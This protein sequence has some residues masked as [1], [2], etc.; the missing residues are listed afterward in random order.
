MESQGCVDTFGS[1]LCLPCRPGYQGDGF[2]CLPTGTISVAPSSIFQTASVGLSAALTVISS[3]NASSTVELAPSGLSS[4]RFS[5]YNP[6]GTL[7]SS[8]TLNLAANSNFTFFVV[9]P[10][11]NNSLPQ[12][13]L[14]VSLINPG[15]AARRVTNPSFMLIS[16]QA[17]GAPNGV[18][19]LNLRSTLTIALNTPYTISVYRTPPPTNA[20]MPSLTVQWSLS[21]VVPQNGAVV[22]AAGEQYSNFTLTVPNDG[23]PRLGYSAT[24]SLLPA[25]DVTLG[26]T[27]SV[28]IQIPASN[29]PYGYF[30]FPV[31]SAFSTQGQTVI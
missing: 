5:F 13:L 6:N 2:T 11:S 14:N 10:A 16:V 19:N 8:W 9:F 18:V 28:S 21:T 25:V 30:Q 24:L 17:S 23:I 29:Y 26:L 20:P 12:A 3:S 7:L 31:L 4:D 1:Y 22:F 27:P 15:G